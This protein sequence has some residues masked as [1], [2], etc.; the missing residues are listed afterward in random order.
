MSDEKNARRSVRHIEVF[1]LPNHTVLRTAVKNLGPVVY[2][3]AGARPLTSMPLLLLGAAS[4]AP[5]ATVTT[6]AATRP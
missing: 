2:G 3:R 4:R 1:G 5:T 6:A